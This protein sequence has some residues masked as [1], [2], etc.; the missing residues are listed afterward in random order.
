MIWPVSLGLLLPVARLPKGEAHFLG[1]AVGLDKR[2]QGGAIFFIHMSKEDRDEVIPIILLFAADD[3]SPSLEGL[4]E[5][6]RRELHGDLKD[7]H[8]IEG[9]R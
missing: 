3:G 1:F 4:F 9:P 8:V 2:S 7:G 6:R 5:T